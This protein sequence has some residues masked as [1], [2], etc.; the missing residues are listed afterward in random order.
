MV[1]NSL[2]ARMKGQS[3]NTSR[4]LRGMMLGAD[5]GDMTIPRCMDHRI[6]NSLLSN[7][8]ATCILLKEEG[9]SGCPVDC[10]DS[11]LKYW[12]SLAIAISWTRNSSC[13]SRDA[14]CGS[15]CLHPCTSF[16]HSCIHTQ[17][18]LKGGT[19]CV[20]FYW[21]NIWTISVE[22]LGSTADPMWFC[23]LFPAHALCPQGHILGTSPKRICLHSVTKV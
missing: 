20:F 17:L 5:H 10:H 4:L 16:P 8:V 1:M 6:H 22:T 15:I 2:W 23:S 11:T 13:W 9:S 12:M 7:Q 14:P 19:V 3:I 21:S 18:V